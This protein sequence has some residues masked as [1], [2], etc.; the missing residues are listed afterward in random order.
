[1]VSIQTLKAI[2][3]SQVRGRVF[4]ARS[5]SPKYIDTPGSCGDVLF[6]NGASDKRDV[7]T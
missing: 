3:L 4:V 2:G 6:Q 5:R 7:F 1:M